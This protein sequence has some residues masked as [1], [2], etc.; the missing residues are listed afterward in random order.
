MD[1]F[2]ELLE[3]FSR[4]HDR[5]LRLLEMAGRSSDADALIATAN[6]Q[7]SPMWQPAVTKNPSGK[8]VGV[9]ITRDGVPKGGYLGRDG[10][11]LGGPNQYDLSNAEGLNKFY[12]LFSEDEG[13]DTNKTNTVRPSQAV[14]AGVTASQ[15]AFGDDEN[16]ESARE[17][18]ISV[19]EN[20]G[21][22]L[23][24]ALVVAGLDPSK[25]GRLFVGA[26]N[27]SFES[28]LS[29]SN[30]YLVIDKASGFFKFEEG[31]LDNATVVG[32]AKTME[33]MLDSLKME[34]C[35]SGAFGDDDPTLEPDPFKETFLDNI[36]KT[37][38]GDIVI[39]P[40]GA[41]ISQSLVFTDDTRGRRRKGSGT[42]KDVINKAFE[43]C[44]EKIPVINILDA[45]G[46]GG[47][48]D[49]NTI[50]T[51]YEMFQKIAVLSVHIERIK[52]EGKP[53]PDA[54]AK[55]YKKTR[56]EFSEKMKKLSKLT[57][58][59]FK[60]E[61]EV[62]LTT[63]DKA[64]LDKLKEQFE[65]I[66]D[67]N[68]DPIPGEDTP[69]LIKMA[70]LSVTIMKDRNPKFVT[71]A[72][73][74]TKFG[75]RQDIREYY[76]TE[77]E[78]RDALEKAGLDVSSFSMKTLQEMIEGGHM[79]DSEAQAALAVGLATDLKTRV[80]VLITSLKFYKDVNH[81]TLG[82]G[83]TKTF[84]DMMEEGLMQ[85]IIALGTSRRAGA[86]A[87]AKAASLTGPHLKL[88]NTMLDDLEKGKN[89]DGSTETSEDAWKAMQKY[90]SGLKKVET[91]INKIPSKAKVITDS[92]TTE[93][94]Y[95]NSAERFADTVE[96][97][98]RSG[99]S[100]KELTTG[101]KKRIM[102]RIKLLKNSKENYTKEALYSTIQSEVSTMLIH[103]KVEKDLNSGDEARVK[104]AQRWLAAKAYHAGGSNDP[105]LNETA[106][107]RQTG[108]SYVYNRNKLLKKVVNGKEN[109]KIDMEKSNFEDGLVIYSNGKKSL[110]LS[111]NTVPTR[112]KEDNETIDERRSVNSKTT[113]TANGPTQAGEDKRKDKREVSQNSSTILQALGSLYEALGIIKEKV[114]L[115]NT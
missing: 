49:N 106:V 90:A 96:E 104:N 95:V 42:M 1:F 43:L 48:S 9:F 114:R 73:G 27:E 100:Y 91:T 105:K 85:P 15:G 23:P 53:I 25:Y 20:I 21:R 24:E 46:E 76:S 62:G 79:T 113:L 5:S 19:F 33:D 12:G 61:R 102:S 77:K 6:S 35:K 22:I 64:Y 2:K 89:E 26:P 30:K 101:T 29:K 68:G 78:G 31:T 16:G 47:S 14:P 86:R 4:V 93:R 60:T 66:K 58:I 45:V 55:E 82:G 18:T 94:L 63:E 59:S 39:T 13:G 98:L 69:L 110:T 28:K 17:A 44:G 103:A 80:A 3:S 34:R 51:G 50:G 108:N 112:S 36:K 41:D 115:L 70:Q 71:E 88:I 92:G 54:L 99:N 75:S 67:E 10:L 81:V 72:G 74:E 52:K 7:K 109:W 38:R 40:N 111:T 56:I 83:S 87:R 37:K 32:V 8:D 97:E 84:N 11:V 107:S 65:P 57:S